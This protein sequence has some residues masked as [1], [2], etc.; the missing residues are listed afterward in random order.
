MK[1]KYR[2]I[3]PHDWDI[4]DMDSGKTVYSVGSREIAEEIAAKLNHGDLALEKLYYG[5]CF[6]KRT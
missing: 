1:E 4:K 6:G 5:L 3:H 2:L